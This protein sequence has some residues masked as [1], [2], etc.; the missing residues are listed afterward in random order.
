MLQNPEDTYDEIITVYS[1]E[2][3]REKADAEALAKAE[4]VAR[5]RSIDGTIA[6]CLGC[7]RMTKSG[8]Y[9]CTLRIEPKGEQ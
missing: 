5:E 8:R 1:S 4:R 2:R 3:N 9:A 7:I 6:V